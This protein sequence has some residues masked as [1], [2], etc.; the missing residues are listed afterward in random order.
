MRVQ[1]PRSLVAG[2]LTNFVKWDFAVHV[3]F[4][5]ILEFLVG[6]LLLSD[7]SG[8]QLSHLFTLFIALTSFLM[9]NLCILCK[10]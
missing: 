5:T 6:V 8:H 4:L 2:V 3:S 10:G 9:K 7:I 1:F